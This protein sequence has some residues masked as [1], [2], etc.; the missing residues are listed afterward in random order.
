MQTFKTLIYAVSE[1]ER[2]GI[3]RYRKMRLIRFHHMYKI[4]YVQKYVQYFVAAQKYVQQQRN[5]EQK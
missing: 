1:N 4:V 2:Y 5:Q 3:Q